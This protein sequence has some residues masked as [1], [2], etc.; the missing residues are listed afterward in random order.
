MREKAEISLRRIGEVH[1]PF[2][3]KFGIPHQSGLAGAAGGRIVFEREFAAPDWVRGLEGFSHI[4]VIWGISETNAGISATV[5]PPKLGGN[6]RIGVF[7]SRSPFRP[8]GIALSC[9]R[10]LK[11]EH[12]EH[13]GPVL[14]I[15]GADM[16]DKSPVYDIKPYV[17]ADCHP[18]A[19]VSFA[20]LPEKNLLVSDPGRVLCSLPEDTA[21][22]LR[23]LLS[24]DPRP[25]YH[26]DPERV[27]AMKYE[28]L[29]LHFTVSDDCVTVLRISA[30]RRP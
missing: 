29:E 14:H 17:P 23:Q 19:E 6:R 8:N 25:A 28:D 16:L 21:K 18:E 5:R 1:T 11:V 26:K 2:K 30:P 20:S 10:L 3:S 13:E 24:L 7:A 9:V 22:A 4:W 15:A 27:Y 12:T